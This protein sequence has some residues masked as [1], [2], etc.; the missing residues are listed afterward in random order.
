[1][2][3]WTEA[4]N[5]VDRR[6]GYKPLRQ[7]SLVG[8]GV[9]DTTRIATSH[10]W[11]QATDIHAGDEVLTFDAGLQTV[12][13]VRRMRLNLQA[14]GCDPSTWPL[15]VPAGALGNLAEFIVMPGQSVL[16]ES[17]LAR[18][19]MGSPLVMIHA[20]DLD[21]V[22]GITRVAPSEEV[23]VMSLNFADDQI[24]FGAGGALF[25]CEGPGDLLARGHVPLRHRYRELSTIEADLILSHE[26]APA[27][28]SPGRLSA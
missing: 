1:M 10:G 26:I 28:A 6:P 22:A 15:C 2:L 8:A 14:G 23:G 21:S 18:D 20:R 5:Q 16:V 27:G 25:L 4:D 9:F 13:L 7:I 11:R 12:K 19:L 3:I 17:E 24:V